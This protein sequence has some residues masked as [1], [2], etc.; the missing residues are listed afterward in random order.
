MNPSTSS[1]VMENRLLMA[2]QTAQPDL[3]RALFLLSNEPIPA[4]S[5][6]TL[7]QLAQEGQADDAMAYLHSIGAGYAG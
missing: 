5:H 1:G 6:K 2:A 3:E 4:F 7:M